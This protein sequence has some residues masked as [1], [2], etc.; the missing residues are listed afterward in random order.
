MRGFGSHWTIGLELCVTHHVDLG[1]IFVPFCMK[2]L[3]IYLYVE[4]NTDSINLQLQLL[5]MAVSTE[6]INERTVDTLIHPRD[7]LH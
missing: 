5:S 1:S 7:Q 2:L 4:E 3:P 6:F